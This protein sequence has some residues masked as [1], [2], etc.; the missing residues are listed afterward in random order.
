MKMTPRER[1]MASV[2]HQ[3]PDSL[4]MDLGSNVSAGISGMAYG[5]LKEYLG[6]TTGHNRIYDVV[7]QVAQPEIQVLDIIG[8]DV[9]DVGRVFNTEDS[10]WY[11]V[12]LS[13][14]V[15]AQ[16]P[17]WFRPR[18]NKDGSYEYFDCEGT[19]IAKMPNGGMCFDQ[20]YFPYKED[21]PKN[22]NDLDKEMGKVI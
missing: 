10:N 15:A 3:N 9:L 6:I 19:L 5:K 13:N 21:Y 22:Y 20:Q 7:Q 12:T 14:G 11:D 4:P 17:G 18:H 16:W 8:A 1:V 2:N